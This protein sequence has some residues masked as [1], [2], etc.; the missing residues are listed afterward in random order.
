MRP[1]EGGMA[2][3]SGEVDRQHRL[4]HQAVGEPL[5][6]AGPGRARDSC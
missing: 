5:V 6:K 4:G 3:L 2:W 1:T